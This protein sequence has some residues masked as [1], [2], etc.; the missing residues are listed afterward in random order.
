MQQQTDLSPIPL[1]ADL[2]KEELAQLN[3]LAHAVNYKQG[4]VLFREGEDATSHQAT[5]ADPG[6]PFGVFVV[7]NGEFEVRQKGPDGSEQTLLKLGPGG[8]FGLTSVL[9]EGPRRASAYAVTDG[10][11]LVLSR[12]TFHQAL[13]AHPT[14]AIGIM[15]SMARHVRE[16]SA[17]L[18][19][20]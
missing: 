17:L 5:Q 14:I 3:A 2:P 9:D 11:C 18:A 7:T 1:F 4:D 13:I 8:V 15:R 6:T 20:S 19:H 10:T 16:L 12:I